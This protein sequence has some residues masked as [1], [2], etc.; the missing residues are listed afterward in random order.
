[1]AEA[2]FAELLEVEKREALGNLLAV[3]VA[4]A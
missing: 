4:L 1:V 2:D 3:D